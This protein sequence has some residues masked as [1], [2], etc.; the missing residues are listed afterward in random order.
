[1]GRLAMEPEKDGLKYPR[2]QE[3]LQAALIELDQQRLPEKVA[4]AETAIVQ[5]L[6]ELADSADSTEERQAL[7]TASS[8]LLTLQKMVLK[9]PGW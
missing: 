2:W 1:M 9:Y 7:A 4:A 3:P 6:Q 8:S 5:R